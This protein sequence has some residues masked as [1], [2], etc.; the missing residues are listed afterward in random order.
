M[1]SI[2]RLKWEESVREEIE[3]LLEKRAQ[4]GWTQ[5]DAD[6]YNYLKKELGED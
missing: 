5:A 4:H 3:Y 2:Y 1:S 6:R